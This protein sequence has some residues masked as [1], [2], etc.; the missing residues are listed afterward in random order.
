[1]GALSPEELEVALAA[2]ADVVA[3]HEPFVAR[4][5]AAGVPARLHVKLDTGMGRLG[6]RDPDEARRVAEAIASAPD[7][8]LAGAMTHFATAD[9]VG[10]D[11][12]GA[13]LERFAPFAERLRAEHPG[14]LVHAANSAATLR[15]SGGA[16]RPRPLWDR[17]LRHGPVPRGAGGPRPG[18]G[19]GAALL[20]RRP[21]AARGGRERGL[22]PA[23]R[24]R[25]RHD[26][27]RAADRLRRRV[28]SRAHEQR[29]RPRGRR[30]P[31]ARR[32]GLDGQRHRRPRP[33]A[34]GRPSGT[35]RCS[36]ARRAPSGSPRRRSP[37]G[38]TRSTTRSR[39]RSLRVSRASTTATGS[40][41]EPRAGRRARRA[42]RRAGLGRR[43]S[44]ARPVPRALDRRCRPGRPG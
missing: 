43:G 38:W 42:R 17:R 39:A 3:W 44:R 9:E 35:R 21:Q 5:A 18:A 15:D 12:F 25:A 29:R 11:F 40:R 16:L 6:T 10:D 4:A 34:G 33:G 20:R 14:I 36:S 2:D 32:H 8:E 41:R 26:A 31:A 1:M 13:Q 19:A 7:L 30:A 23:L 37:G 22:R 27:R 24:R 28:A